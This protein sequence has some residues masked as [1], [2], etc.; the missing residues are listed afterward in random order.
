V[1]Q[2]KDAATR[3]PFLVVLHTAEGHSQRQIAQMLA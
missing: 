3:I 1:S 2:I